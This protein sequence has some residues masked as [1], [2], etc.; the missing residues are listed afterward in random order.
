MSGSECREGASPPVVREVRLSDIKYIVDIERKSFKYPYPLIAFITLMNLY[1]N[2]FLV[3]EFCGRVVGYVSAAIDKD[4]FGHVISIA[5]DPEF[6]LRGVG[7]LLME[8][9]ERRL[10][11]DGISKCKLEVAVSNSGAIKMYNTLGYKAVRVLSNYYP[12]GEDAYLMVKELT[13]AV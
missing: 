4:G 8:A 5:V 3:C 2:Y 13:Q 7:K 10:S 12:D 1:P 11:R 6:R 9:V